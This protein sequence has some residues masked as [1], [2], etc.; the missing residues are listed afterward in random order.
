MILEETIDIMTYSGGALI[1]V[2]GIYIWV[3]ER[4][5]QTGKPT[6]QNI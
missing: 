5:L 6:P 1:V 4:R 2:A 3:R